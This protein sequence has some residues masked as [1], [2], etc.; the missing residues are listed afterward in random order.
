MAVIML[1]L[2]IMT[3]S[4]TCLIAG[5]ADT[6]QVFF[7]SDI[8]PSGVLMLYDRIS[9]N[10][11]GR[12]GVK[13]H[14]GEEGNTNFIN[15]SLLKPLVQ[16]LD[17]GF[18]ETNVLYRSPR[19]VTDSHIKLAIDHGFSYA[20]IDILN[21]DGDM[22]I[23]FSGRH[24][25]SIS[26]G[27]NMKN[28]DYFVIV[29]HFK[30]HGLAGFGGAIK[31]IAMGLA[32]IPGKM[33]MHASTIPVYRPS[34]CISCGLCVS[35]CPVDAISLDPL[36]ID[37]EKCIGCGKCIGTCPTSAMN[38]PWGSTDKNVFNERL[39]EYAKGISENYPMV[40]INFLIN[41]SKDCDCDGSAQPPFMDDIGILASTDIVAIE[42]ASLDLI[43]RA[44]GHEDT[45]YDVNAVSGKNQI[46]YANELGMGNLEYRLVNLDRED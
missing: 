23:P 2:A 36:V 39:V 10:V 15:P 32:S 7:T 28:Y 8:S 18:V 29:T 22:E 3:I 4:C 17:A 12:I 25:Q 30:G 33:A 26:V 44:Y 5:E 13:V 16:K 20:P 11:T 9:V 42:K 35:Q 37:L 19:R 14:F 43:N 31:N 40:F 21:A 6:S 46:I 34:R 41:I 1:V 38:V 45:F 24:F 27:K